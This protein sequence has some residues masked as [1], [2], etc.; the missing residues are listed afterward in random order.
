MQNIIREQIEKATKL[1]PISSTRLIDI[2]KRETGVLISARK[3]RHIV[4]SLRVDQKLPV[5]ATRKGSVGYYLCRSKE[6]FEAY[7]KEVRNHALRELTTIKMIRSDY[8]G[9]KQMEL[10]L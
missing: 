5:L 8:F 3:V 2:V 9:Q 10:F 1:S 7:A 4:E 6:E